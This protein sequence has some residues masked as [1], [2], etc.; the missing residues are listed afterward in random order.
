MP[1]RKATTVAEYSR[2]I[3]LVLMGALAACGRSQPS[4][5]SAS[6]RTDTLPAAPETSALVATTP[7]QSADA[8]PPT[9]RWAVCSVEKRLRQSGF[10]ARRLEGDAPRRPG[11][12][13]EPIV[14]SLGSARLEVFLYGD[15]RAMTR[16]MSAIDTVLVVPPG[17][18]SPW[19]TAPLLVR[20]GN[21]AAVLLTQNARQAERLM[22]A[23]TA[24]APQ[25]GLPR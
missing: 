2:H 25:P 3:V 21:L 22:L 6:S 9:G 14:Y 4:P 16:D 23:L 20:S 19:E 11:F 17:I 10:V 15:E 5:D 13:V 1:A 24:G 8:C 12:S 18:P 7:P